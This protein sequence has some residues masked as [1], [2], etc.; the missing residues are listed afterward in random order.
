MRFLGLLERNQSYS[1][2]QMNQK[3][4]CILVLLLLAMGCHCGLAQ[5]PGFRWAGGFLGPGYIYQNALDQDAAGNVYA[6]GFFSNQLDFDPGLGVANRFASGSSDIF[7]TKFDSMGVLNWVRTF[8]AGSIDNG[9]CGAVDR[10]GNVYVAGTFKQTVDF[11]PGPGTY[12]L[13]AGANTHAVV[14]KL[15]PNGDLIWARH[16]VSSNLTSFFG[17]GVDRVGNVLLSGQFFGTADFD[18]GVG[19]YSLSSVNLG[20]SD[21][22][23]MKLDSA[24]NFV[25]ANK[26]GGASSDFYRSMAVDTAGNALLVGIFSGMIDVDPGPAVLNLSSVSSS[27]MFVQKLNPAGQMLWTTIPEGNAGSYL[28]AVTTDPKGDVYAVGTVNGLI[29]MNPGPGSYLL[30]SGVGEAGV[31]WKLSRSGAFRWAGVLPCTTNTSEL[32]EVR[33]DNYGSVYLGGTIVGTCDIDPTPVTQ[34]VPTVGGQVGVIIRLDTAGSLIWTRKIG[35]LGG[36]AVESIS[37]DRGGDLLLG[38]A[39]GDIVDLNPGL[40]TYNLIA[41]SINNLFIAKWSNCMPASQTI[42]VSGCGLVSV[43]GQNYSSSGTYTQQLMTSRG[44]DSLLTVQVTVTQPSALSMSQASCDSF[45]LN[46]VTYDSSGTYTQL[47]TNAFG[48]DS[49]ITLQLTVSASAAISIVDTACTSYVLNNQTYAASGTYTQQLTS[50]AGCDSM[51]TLHLTILSPSDTVLQES[52]CHAFL[53]NGQ[54]YTSSGTYLQTIPN[55]VDCDSTITLH[56][57]VNETDST[58]QL[59][60]CDSLSLNGQLFSSTGTY[61]QVIP[62]SVGCDSLITL[63]LTVYQTPNASIL[64][65]SNSLVAAPSGA[66]YQWLRCDSD[67]VAISFAT[68]QTFVP[69]QS[70]GYAVVVNAGGCIDTSN[71]VSVTVVSSLPEVPIGLSLY[72]NPNDGRFHLHLMGQTEDRYAITVLD[73]LGREVWAGSIVDGEDKAIELGFLPNGLY[74]L[75][76][77][78]PE[79]VHVQRFVK[80]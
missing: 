21:A 3:R 19:T 53:L 33:Q 79:S 39:F 29:D 51:L 4:T 22:F 65:Q 76:L 47:L 45:V 50:I 59:T 58:L 77:S 60:A 67:T 40:A 30:N 36:E 5:V 10:F 46:N 48:C 73:A 31:I 68:G 44:C 72:P 75:Q 34:M 57:S 18:P 12:F 17:M 62:N 70:G 2:T 23:A 64:Q 63:Q 55:A 20:Y 37:A 26:I 11:D 7:V 35:N 43:N 14:V 27:V 38:G 6:S 8:G 69:T 66:L 25:W 24:G 42:A 56:L 61:L 80:Q 15:T 9:H 74:S 32:Y 28:Y 16:L 1:L 49:L 13:S 52:V 41:G 78:Q 54:N 71:C